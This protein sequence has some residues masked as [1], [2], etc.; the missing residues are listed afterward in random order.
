MKTFNVFIVTGAITKTGTLAT[1][2]NKPAED[3]NP[4]IQ[5]GYDSLTIYNHTQGQVSG[6]MYADP[7]N[8]IHT[9]K[10]STNDALNEEHEGD[11]KFCWLNCPSIN[12][13]YNNKKGTR[14]KR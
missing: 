1:I 6:P 12:Q 9:I 11:Y 10:K 13:E 4:Y 3:T 5:F 8:M 2:S 7:I 14:M